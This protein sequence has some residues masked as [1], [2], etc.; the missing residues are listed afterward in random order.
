MQDGAG[1]ALA[2][3]GDS[4]VVR[5]RRDRDVGK[6]LAGRGPALRVEAVVWRRGVMT[7]LDAMLKPT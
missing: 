7:A 5:D 1:T 6:A 2:W 4:P 3:Q